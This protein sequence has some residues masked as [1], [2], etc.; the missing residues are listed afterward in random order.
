VRQQVLPQDKFSACQFRG[1]QAG[2]SR[3]CSVHVRQQVLPQD[4]FSALPIY[5]SWLQKL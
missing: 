3:P 5:N 2:R 4:T 1:R